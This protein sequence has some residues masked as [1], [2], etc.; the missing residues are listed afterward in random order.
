MVVTKTRFSDADTEQ[1][2]HIQ[3]CQCHSA[4]PLTP[5]LSYSWTSPQETV[6][7]PT[8]GEH[9][10]KILILKEAHPNYIWPDCLALMWGCRVGE[11]K[12]LSLK[13]ILCKSQRQLQ[14]LCSRK[15]RD[16][17]SVCPKG[18]DERWGWDESC[19]HTL[20]WGG[21]FPPTSTIPP[22]QQILVIGLCLAGTIQFQC[23]QQ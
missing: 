22:T 8:Q 21:I 4:L 13:C 19:T 18:R 14:F 2:F 11:C 12:E 3:L 5:L 9:S 17:L 1:D 7:I 15:Q 10:H 23:Y 6:P 16:V 20:H